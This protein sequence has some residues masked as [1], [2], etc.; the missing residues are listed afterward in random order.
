MKTKYEVVEVNRSEILVDVSLL[1]KSEEV[2]FNATQM[3][4]PFGKRPNDFWKQP[5]NEEYRN[6]LITLQEG[7]KKK[8]GHFIIVPSPPI[9]QLCCDFFHIDLPDGS[10]KNKAGN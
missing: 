3:A 8:E 2:F 5:Q 4:K 7:N 1:I 9:P 10:N 6:A